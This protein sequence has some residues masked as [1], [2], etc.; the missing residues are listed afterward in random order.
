MTAV[1]RFA[2]SPT[3]PAARRLAGRG[4]GELARR[5]R[6]RPAGAL[7]GAH[8]GRRHRALPARHGRAHP[9][10]AGRLRPAARRAAGLADAARRALRARARAPARPL[11]LAYPCGCSRKDI[12]EALALR[13]EPHA[14][15][16][17]AR[18]P[19]HLPRRPA[20]QAA[21]RLAL[22][23]RA[24]RGGPDV[25]A[26]LLDRPP[27]RLRSSRTS[28]TRSATSCSSAPTA[29][30]PTSSPWWSTMPTRA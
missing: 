2:P 15:P 18:L 5:A 28:R 8:R 10:A 21:A 22:R 7:A 12:D 20:R 14:P 30:G 4:A 9:V 26:A 27:A 24:V 29:P 13:G 17:R 23:R 19:R 6:P 11:Q 25:E 3:G 16:R 1:G